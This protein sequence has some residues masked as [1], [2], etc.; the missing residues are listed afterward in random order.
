MTSILHDS[1]SP[2]NVG[3][4]AEPGCYSRKINY[5]AT[6]KQISALAELSQ[7]CHQSIVVCQNTTRSNKC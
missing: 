5:N 3:H 4:C 2:T 1:E 6:G 7:E